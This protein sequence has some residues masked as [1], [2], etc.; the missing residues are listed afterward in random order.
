[1][2]MHSKDNLLAHLSKIQEEINIQFELIKDTL[3]KSMERVKEK[4]R[5]N[6]EKTIGSSKVILDTMKLEKLMH[7]YDIEESQFGWIRAM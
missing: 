2:L 3:E 4:Y 1:M 7:I 6:V 5:F